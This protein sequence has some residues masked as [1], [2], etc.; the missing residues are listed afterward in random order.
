[1]MHL[2]NPPKHKYKENIDSSSPYLK[3]WGFDHQILHAIL[4]DDL[5]IIAQHFGGPL[6]L[7]G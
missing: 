1:M 3:T 5:K 2:V 4:V 7:L 6:M